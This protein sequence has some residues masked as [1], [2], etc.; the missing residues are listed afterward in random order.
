MQRTSIGQSTRTWKHCFG[1]W[2]K[3]TVNWRV[4]K[5]VSIVGLRVGEDGRIA[6]NHER[7][8][9]KYAKRE[10]KHPETKYGAEAKV[11]LKLGAGWKIVGWNWG[12]GWRSKWWLR[13]GR[14]WWWL[15]RGKRWWSREAI[16]R[17]IYCQLFLNWY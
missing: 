10:R 11:D 13:R 4:V 5:K 1:S 7:I 14:Y 3:G 16:K 15:I 12:R 8:D 2:S 6:A 9:G 17:M